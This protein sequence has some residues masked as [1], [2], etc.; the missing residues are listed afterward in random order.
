MNSKTNNHSSNGAT[1]DP[2]N[3]IEAHDRPANDLFHASAANNG[4]ANDHFNDGAA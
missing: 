2:F 4:E 1:I 3:N